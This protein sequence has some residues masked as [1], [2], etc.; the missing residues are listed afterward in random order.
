MIAHTHSEKYFLPLLLDYRY[1][2]VGTQ[3]V[4]IGL[5]EDI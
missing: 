5:T 1:K 3:S 4:V 2:Q